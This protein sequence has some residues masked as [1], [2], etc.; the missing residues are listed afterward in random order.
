MYLNTLATHASLHFCSKTTNAC[1]NVRQATIPSRQEIGESNVS[2]NA[3]TL[4]TQF[5]RTIPVKDVWNPA[6]NARISK[7]V[8]VVWMGGIFMNKAMNTT[9]VSHIAHLGI[10]PSLK[11]TISANCAGIHVLNASLKIN[12]CHAELAICIL[13]K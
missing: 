7:C 2:W 8:K 3:L 1:Q 5:S 13:S 11:K 6:Q 4:T 9:D 10:M 12:A